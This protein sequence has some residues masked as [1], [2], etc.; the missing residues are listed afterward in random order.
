[1]TCGICGSGISAE[2]K[3]KKLKDG[4]VNRHVYYGCSK[5][6]D[7]NCK[8]GYINEEGLIKQF[9]KLIESVPLH[10][11][12]VK[13]KIKHELLRMKRFQKSVLQIKEDVKITELDIKSYAKFILREGSILEKREILSCLEGI[14]SL[15]NKTL[16]CN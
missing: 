3:F 4:S 1:M 13:E 15:S 5:S 2:E 10:E 12:T 11:N 14:M 16:V 9:E 6:K 8:C 7:K